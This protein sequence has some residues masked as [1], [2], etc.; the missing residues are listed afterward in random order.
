VALW[1][2]RGYNPSAAAFSITA[3][4][5]S[6]GV[7]T[8][9]IVFVVV[10]GVTTA[11]TT[12]A[13]TV[14]T[15]TVTQIQGLTTVNNVWWAAYWV[16]GMTNSAV[17]TGTVTGAAKHFQMDVAAFTG[18][19]VG[20]ISA[21]FARVGSVNTSV[22]PA[23]TAT[24][25]GSTVVDLWA[26]RNTLGATVVAVS[27]GTIDDQFKAANLPVSPNTNVTTHTAISNFAPGTTS[28]PA[29][30]G[31]YTDGAATNRA[32]TNG[33]GI[34][35]ELLSGTPTPVLT[36]FSTGGIGTT[37]AK[38]RIDGTPG[39]SA[40]VTAATDT[41]LTT[42]A[43]SSSP[44][45]LDAD[46][47]GIV[48]LTGL[49]SATNYFYGVALDAQPKADR[50][51]F[52]TAATGA[53]SYSFAAA[54][55]L[56]NGG[57]PFV[58]ESISTRTGTAG[59]TAEFFS[60]LGD[61]HYR[62]R[63]TANTATL[64][65][66]YREVLARTRHKA[67]A[68]ALPWSYTWSDHE[69][70][71][72]NSDSTSLGAGVL[73]ANRATYARYFPTYDLPAV[74]TDTAPYFSWVRGRVRFIMTD[75][76]SYMSAIA[77]TDNSSKTKL[78]ATQK[79]WWKDEFVA[80]KAAGQVVVWFHEDGGWTSTSAFVGDD[81]W[82]AYST[83]RTELANYV[84]TLGMA[85]SALIVHGDFHALAADDGTNS[86]G[87]IPVVCVSPLQQSYYMPSQAQWSVGEYPV[88][89]PGGTIYHYGWFDVTDTGTSS[90][91]IAFTGYSNDNTAGL[92]ADT[93]RITMTSSLT[94]P[95]GAN[96]GEFLPF[97]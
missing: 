1:T 38:V 12:H 48:A 31:T 64:L 27:T 84:T 57:D 52:R 28:V 76:R 4:A 71:P 90:I 66:D 60:H 2:A 23:F 20:N 44:V 19:G 72:D 56:A 26:E 75:G 6:S 46:G 24:D 49:A 95:T 79:Q 21:P 93:A 97:L 88:S 29:I 14:T 7:S 80:A 61:L 82:A 30:T 77:D 63:D 62:E 35:V 91:S 17:L 36:S 39:A 32:S 25:A 5:P 47:L 22:L 8:S 41:G 42:G 54:S 9:D 65:A 45:I 81:T 73:A 89:N 37:T 58:L 34:Q 83:E 50:G 33:A 40:V 51:N 11:P 94:V 53:Y 96:S 43:V 85:G 68:A 69:L 86:A 18:S 59:S 13:L 10:A 67:F 74:N 70:G 87:G 3:T 92:G 15:G 78:G 55:C 16:T